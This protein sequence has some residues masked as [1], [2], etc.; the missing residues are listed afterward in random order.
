[1]SALGALIGLI[2]SI[3]LIIR[4]IS[5][6]YSLILGAFIGGLMSGFTLTET[7]SYMI[8]GVKGITP[9][10]LRI[11][12]AGVLSGVLIKTGAAASISNGI[13][14]KLGRSHVYLA[15][16]LAT[17]FLTAIGVFID[18]AV[19]TVAPVALSIGKKL[20][21]RKATLLLVM[22]GG[23]KCGNIIS[24]NPN[25]IIAAENFGVDLFSVMYANILPA[26][27]G[28]AFTVYV[29]ARLMPLKGDLVQQEDVEK[30]QESLPS[31]TSSMVA[32]FVTIVLL[33]FRPLFGYGIDPLIALPL[34]GLTGAIAMN[35]VKFLR[36][37]MSYG[38]ARM[39]VVAILLIGTG[40]LA[41]I[42][43]ASS[44][45]DVLLN[46]LVETDLGEVLI[47]PLSGILMGAATA[48]STAGAT[49]ASSSFA[50][51]IL[52]AGISG[53]WGAA[54]INAG[55]TF[56]DHLPHG[57]FFHATGGVTNVDITNRI[58][59]IP[60]ESAI[61]FVLTFFS[62]IAYSIFSI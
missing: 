18:V 58:R 47:A 35:K 33:A 23:G 57:S 37:G 2:L 25:T 1:M 38:L 44:I 41:G 50:E 49:V 59:L 14:R 19:I 7:V 43:K 45:K 13:I 21:I 27:L 22:I 3:V 30:E 6:A 28:L 26:I 8:E 53:I 51:I 46:A 24:P 40:T 48:S 12:T 10:I 42:I 9:A 20:S 4:K 52:K 62:V 11:L 56:L 61:G 17:F 31:F 60:Y 15:L 5:P 32:P 55:A 16:A 54:M 36:E 39:S 29:I 34:G